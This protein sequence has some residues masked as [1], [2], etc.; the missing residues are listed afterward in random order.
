MMQPHDI[1]QRSPDV[2]ARKIGDETILVPVVAGIGNMDD[3]LYTVKGS[4]EEIWNRLDG[5]STLDDIAK[6]LSNAYAASYEIVLQ[7]VSGFCTELCERN[8]AS[9]A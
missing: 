7:D 3:D 8:L 6:A 2:V 1:L 5:T 4:A 9:K